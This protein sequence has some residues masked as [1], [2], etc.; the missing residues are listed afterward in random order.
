M[1]KVNQNHKLPIM[2]QGYNHIAVKYHWFRENMY[3]GDCSVK[4]VYEKY[5]KSNIFTG[6]LKGGILP[7][8][9]KLFCGWYIKEVY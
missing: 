2:N 7:H 5:Q 4:K 6:Y 9:L 1:V 3:I 8:L